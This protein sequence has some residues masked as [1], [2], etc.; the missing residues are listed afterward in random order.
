MNDL[1]GLAI[2]GHGGRR[3]WDRI[4]R[5][6]VSMSITGA[7]CTR[8][9]RPGWLAGVMMEGDTDEERLTIVPFPRPGHYTTWEPGRQRIHTSDGVLVAERRDSAA[10]FRGSTRVAPLDEF[11]VAQVAGE[12]GWTYFVAPFIF[13]RGDFVTEETWPWREDGRV[14]R[15]LLVTFP[16]SLVTHSRQQTYYFD[17]T[18]LLRRLDY[19]VLHPGGG[20][21]A[22]YPSHY[23]EF[24]GIMVPTRRVVYDRNPDGF[25]DRS[26]VSV[27]IGVTDVTFS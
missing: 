20:P 18:G 23:R 13:T 4:S 25:P 17:D 16:D 8:M 6:R 14:W 7:I 3:R 12:A 21:A 10:A 5:F 2:A 11:Q 24:D 15:A 27:D 26:S 22:H 19:T 9:G 1:L